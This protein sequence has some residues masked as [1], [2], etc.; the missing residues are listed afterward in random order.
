MRR[1]WM[2]ETM[3]KN[4]KITDS[5]L[6]VSLALVDELCLRLGDRVWASVLEARG[7]LE[8]ERARRQARGARIPRL[9]VSVFA[10]EES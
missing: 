2:E 9:C 1:E 3:S 10:P 6:A 7:V 5:R 4:T 8:R